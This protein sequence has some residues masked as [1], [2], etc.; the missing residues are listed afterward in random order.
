MTA[1]RRDGG[2]FALGEIRVT[3]NQIAGQ[4]YTNDGTV[5]DVSAR[6]KADGTVGDAALVATPARDVRLAAATLRDGVL[7][8]TYV[9]DGQTGSFAGSR[10]SALAE[11]PWDP[12]FDGSYEITLTA[13]DVVVAETV[14]TVAH[15]R[16]SAFIA[17]EGGYTLDA[18]GRVTED[19]T[20]V[21]QQVRSSNGSNTL[22][23]ASIDPD[24]MTV[25]GIFLGDGKVGVVS[26]RRSD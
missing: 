4:L 6:L 24:R 15:G 1:Y 13:N 17:T 5:V 12:R 19:G 10:M 3:Q 2:H 8:G 25:E 22:A 18:A 16:M 11:L 9:I 7:E 21:L 20:L 14:M 26:G 23:E